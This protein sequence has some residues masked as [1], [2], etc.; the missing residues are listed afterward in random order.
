MY[1]DEFLDQYT[2]IEL[3]KSIRE[4]IDPL[5]GNNS[6][7][8]PPVKSGCS[9]PVRQSIQVHN[10]RLSRSPSPRKLLHRV[11]ASPCPVSKGHWIS[12]SGNVSPSKGGAT[13]VGGKY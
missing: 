5:G 4:G 13:T 1:I 6:P 3:E 2:T 10:G 11:N 9:S 12:E 8:K 7:M